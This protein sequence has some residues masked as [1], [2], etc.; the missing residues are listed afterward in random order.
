MPYASKENIGGFK[1]IKYVTVNFYFK[2]LYK[3]KTVLC[4]YIKV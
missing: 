1:F 3:I 2:F 4:S